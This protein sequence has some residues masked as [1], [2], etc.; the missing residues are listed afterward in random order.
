MDYR[1]RHGFGKEDS[2]KKFYLNKNMGNASNFLQFV[3]HI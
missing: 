2:K 3:E 1:V